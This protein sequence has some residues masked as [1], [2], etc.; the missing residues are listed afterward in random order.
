MPGIKDASYAEDLFY[1]VLIG[2]EISTAIVCALG[3]QTGLFI[4]AIV[5]TIVSI[6]TLYKPDL[7]LLQLNSL[8]HVIS[9]FIL[10][11]ITISTSIQHSIGL[12]SV[13][14]VYCILCLTM[15]F[16]IAY[17]AFVCSR[18]LK[19]NFTL[20]WQLTPQ[21]TASVLNQSIDNFKQKINEITDLG[22]YIPDS[23]F[24]SEA[25]IEH[26]RG[27]IH[28]ISLASSNF[29]NNHQMYTINSSNENAVN[30]M[31][32]YGFT[33][34]FRKPTESVL[35]PNS[36]KKDEKLISPC[37]ERNCMNSFS[38]SMVDK[39]RYKDINKL[40]KEFNQNQNYYV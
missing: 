14:I 36:L 18:K 29:I 4:G 31:N 1:I 33:S 40:Q 17:C 10:G 28:D 19:R 12:V 3:K 27:N 11:I 30:I 26:S 15:E 13:D 35:T 39:G 8:V 20:L 16:V 37:S 24:E 9:P 38:P 23:V 32:N 34:P 6:W 7:V 2:C 25:S 5:P 22:V 21:P